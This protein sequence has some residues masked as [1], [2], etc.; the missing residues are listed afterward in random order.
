[1]CVPSNIDLICGQVLIFQGGLLPVSDDTDYLSL[2]QTQICLFEFA[3]KYFTFNRAVV[4]AKWA[5]QN[6]SGPYFDYS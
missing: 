6:S 3:Y 5:C 1:M 2:L 4:T